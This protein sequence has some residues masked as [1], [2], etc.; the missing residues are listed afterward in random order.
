MQH[1][2]AMYGATYDSKYKV[3]KNKKASIHSA[4]TFC[5]ITAEG[6]YETQINFK[7]KSFD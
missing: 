5:P 1:C 3:G 2:N 6:S 4:L 7:T